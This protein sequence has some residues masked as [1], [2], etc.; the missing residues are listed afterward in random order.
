M[1]YT[2]HM[3]AI[4]GVQPDIAENVRELGFEASPRQLDSEDEEMQPA[5]SDRLAEVFKV[6]VAQSNELKNA[7]TNKP[8]VEAGGAAMQNG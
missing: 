5:C 1:T 8:G 4:D 7:A 6:S 3:V 2:K